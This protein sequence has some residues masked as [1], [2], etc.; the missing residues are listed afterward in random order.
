MIKNHRIK[1]SMKELSEP[2]LVGE[3]I[4]LSVS[5]VVHVKINS[6]KLL[7]RSSHRKHVETVIGVIWPKQ[8]KVSQA[9]G[10]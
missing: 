3:G 2:Q 7:L 9:A 8:C 5:R 4:S 10:Y 6:P 1:L